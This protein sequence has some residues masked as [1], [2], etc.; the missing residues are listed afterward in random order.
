MKKIYGILILMFMLGTMFSVLTVT[1]TGQSATV[2]SPGT[3]GTA[4]LTIANNKLC[5]GGAAALVIDSNSYTVQAVQIDAYDTHYVHVSGSTYVGDVEPCASIEI[6]LPVRIDNDTP[7]GIY[8]I[9]ITLHAYYTSTGNSG[10]KNWITR[11]SIVTITVSNS[12]GVT[13][14]TPKSVDEIGI[15]PMVITNNGDDMRNAQLYLNGSCYLRNTSILYVGDLG[16]TTSLFLPVDCSL[17]DDGMNNVKVVLTY[18]D[19]LGNHK[20]NVILTPVYV[21]KAR[22]N[23]DIS[24]KG[25]L[26]SGSS[27]T[28]DL[29]ISSNKMI[30]AAELKE[31]TL[32]LNDTNIMLSNSNDSEIDVGNLYGNKSISIPIKLYTNLAPG[33]HYMNVYAS[34]VEDNL[35]RTKAFGVPIHVSIADGINAYLSENTKSKQGNEYTISVIVSNLE[36]TDVYNVEA[37]LSPKNNDGNVQLIGAT[38]KYIGKLS[39]DDFTMVQFKYK[40]KDSNLKSF[41]VTIAMKFKDMGGQWHTKNIERNVSMPESIVKDSNAMNILIGVVVLIIVLAALWKYGRKHR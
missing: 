1:N 6:K 13:L 15:L 30:P 40:L 17:A 39:N 11:Y 28:M 21:K 37:S 16:R 38:D 19:K 29:V 31:I 2:F 3:I 27:S 24:A 8:S 34:W 41:P 12:Q 22:P 9:P 32:V 10:T 5:S 36:K 7:T 25:D 4:T 35:V 33:W 18:T 20:S 23:L 14:S 26:I